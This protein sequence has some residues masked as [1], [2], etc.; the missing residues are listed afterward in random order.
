MTH[1][2]VIVLCKHCR[3]A[4]ATSPVPV[5]TDSLRRARFQSSHLFSGYL[6]LRPQFGLYKWAGCSPPAGSVAL[7][8]PRFGGLTCCPHLLSSLTAGEPAALLCCRQCF[9]RPLLR[10]EQNKLCFLTEHTCLKFHDIL[11]DGGTWFSNCTP[12]KKFTR[13]EELPYTDSIPVSSF[14]FIFNHLTSLVLFLTVTSVTFPN[15]L[16]VTEQDLR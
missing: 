4:A 6:S 11:A 3:L 10:S 8:P 9:G 2:T 16:Q 12:Q 15:I 7:S 5:L 13:T 14:G 1:C